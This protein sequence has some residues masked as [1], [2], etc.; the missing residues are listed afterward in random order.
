MYTSNSQKKK[1]TMWRD[2]SERNKFTISG[3]QTESEG[4]LNSGRGKIPNTCLRSNSN[5]PSTALSLGYYTME[6]QAEAGG[7][8][9]GPALMAFTFSIPFSL[10]SHGSVLI[11]RSLVKSIL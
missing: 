11:I 2:H 1:T 7:K 3:S 10:R 9:P 8:A 4:S 6:V 5:G